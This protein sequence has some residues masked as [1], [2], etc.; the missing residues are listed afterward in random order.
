LAKKRKTLQLHKTFFKKVN[1][2]TVA[3]RLLI[4][5]CSRCKKQ[6]PGL[7]PAIDRYDGP[8]FR[9]VRRFLR[10][11]K[12]DK[13]D[14]YILSAEFGLITAIK[15]I[16]TYDRKMTKER[17]QDMQS[18]CSAALREIISARPYTDI[19]ICAGHVYLEALGDLHEALPFTSNSQIV[20]GGLGKQLAELHDWL[21][22]ESFPPPAELSTNRRRS[23]RL[24]GIEV[25]F[26]AKQVLDLAQRGLTEDA[27]GATHFHSWYV[28]VEGQPVAAKWLVSRI[29]GLPVSTFTAGEARR[30]LIQLGI[31]V[32]RAS[33]IL[34]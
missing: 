26:T 22:G 32:M 1:D 24:R 20:S 25:S 23:P 16:P 4:V 15:P 8:V 28:L 3:Q 18:S 5:S 27:K 17:A 14:I 10:G 7:I 6:E 11:E 29:T 19:C 30:L 33:K 9:L 34:G 31:Q 21:Y 12:L 13:P 2:P